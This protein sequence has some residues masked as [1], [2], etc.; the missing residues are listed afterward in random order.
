MSASKLLLYVVRKPAADER[1]CNEVKPAN[2]RI[3][4]RF[5]YKIDVKN[6]KTMR[7]IF[8]LMCSY[9]QMC[10]LSGLIISFL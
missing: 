5:Y 6:V 1:L 2:I 9:V 10:N 3:V 8:L 4:F 7:R